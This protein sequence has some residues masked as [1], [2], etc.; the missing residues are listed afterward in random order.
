MNCRLSDT[1]EHIT[2]LKDKIMET[3][4]QMSKTN[5]FLKIK[6]V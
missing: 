6:I 3:P 5:K 2:D 4:N 1:E